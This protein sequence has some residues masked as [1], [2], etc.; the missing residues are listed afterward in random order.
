MI[1]PV[2]AETT[3]DDLVLPGDRQAVFR[4]TEPTDEPSAWGLAFA[5]V[6]ATATP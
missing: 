1:V 2:D 5:Q 6:E 4:V 3:R